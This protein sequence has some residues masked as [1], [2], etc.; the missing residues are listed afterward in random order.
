MIHDTARR[1]SM[2]RPP[3]SGPLLALDERDG[4]GWWPAVPRACPSGH[5][6]LFVDP[7]RS[8]ERGRIYC[9]MCAYE[10]STDVVDT[11]RPVQA[12]DATYRCDGCGAPGPVGAG[13]RS[14]SWKVDLCPACYAGWEA[15]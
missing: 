14:A 8:A 13:R 4:S 5:G 11:R 7:P 3:R 6:R 10:A 1:A 9:L 2:A 15:R 12:A